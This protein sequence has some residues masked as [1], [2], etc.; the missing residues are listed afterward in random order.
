MKKKYVWF[1]V[2]HLHLCRSDHQGGMLIMIIALQFV[3]L[4]L[5]LRKIK[6]W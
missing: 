3:L 6:E 1:Q 2:R 5:W 4:F